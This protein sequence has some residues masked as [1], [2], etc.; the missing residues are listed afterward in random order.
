MPKVERVILDVYL[1]KFCQPYD[2]V[3][4]ESVVY[5]PAN[6]LSKIGFT[7]RSEQI[8]AIFEYTTGRSQVIWFVI[9]CVPDL[10]FHSDYVQQNKQAEYNLGID[11][12]LN[13]FKIDTSRR[14]YKQAEYNLGTCR[15]R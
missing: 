8:K 10:C 13:T 15:I 5:T 3:F 11:R 1:V 7:L 9:S 4:L 2:R 12:I 6:T 14:C